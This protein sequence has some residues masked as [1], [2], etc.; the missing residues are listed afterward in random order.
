MTFPATTVYSHFDVSMTATLT[1][2][3]FKH[4]TK[5]HKVRE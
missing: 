3:V 4:T 1:V 5:Q 2:S